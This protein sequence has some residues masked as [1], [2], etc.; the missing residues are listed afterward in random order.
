MNEIYYVYPV[1]RKGSFHLISKA[2]IKHLNSKVKIQEIDESVLDSIF[3]TGSKKILLHPVGYILLGDRVEMFK[4]RIRRLY[5]L[6]QVEQVA[7]RLAGF[8]TADSDR[9]SNIFVDV[10]NHL[11]FVIVPSKWA[12]Q[13]YINSG[14]ETD[15]LV[16]PHGLNNSFLS[17][18]KE[19]THESIV[20]L[21]EIK[22]K[23][24]VKFVL[25]FLLH[26]EYRKGADLV[27]KAIANI[28]Q[29]MDD[30]VL[31]VKSQHPTN[32][33]GDLK[34]INVSGWFDYDGLRRCACLPFSWRGLRI[35]RIGGNCKRFTNV[36]S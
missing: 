32:Y 3:W 4:Q 8:D 24:R 34:C 1:F 29:E 25:F 21:Q 31:V 6:E 7:K 36:S 18:S 17:N 11:D 15:V 20:K 14:V 12:M 30:V 23:H 5:K 2:H 9:I 33:F 22:K 35:E 26:S 16:L 13:S 10:L 28:Q 27:K 19:I